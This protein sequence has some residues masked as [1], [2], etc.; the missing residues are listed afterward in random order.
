MN[1]RARLSRPPNAQSLSLSSPRFRRLP[2]RWA[3]AVALAFG[4]FAAATRPAIGGAHLP[5]G[6]VIEI[7]SGVYERRNVPISV[8]L[9]TGLNEKQSFSLTTQG[10]AVK[11]AAQVLPGHPPRLVWILDHLAV[12]QMRRYEIQPEG[13]DRQ[14]R[15]VTCQD[16]GKGLI[17]SVD[18]RQALRYEHEIVEAPIGLSSLYRRSGQMHPLTTPS[19]RVVTDD[20]SPDHAHQHGFFFAWVNTTFNGRKV[21]FWNQ[22]QKTGTVRH[23]KTLETTSGPVFAQF[24]VQT[25]HEDLT[26]PETPVAVLDEEITAR[27]YLVSDRFLIDYESRQTC[28]SDKPLQLHQYIYGGLGVRGNRA[29]A[30]PSARG[31]AA[32]SI[33]EWPERLSDERRQTP[34][35]RQS[36]PA[37]LGRSFGRR[38]RQGRRAGGARESHE[39]P[40]PAAGSIASQHALFLGLADSRGRIRHQARRDLC[41]ALSRCPA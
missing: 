41:F 14:G 7:N 1:S 17:L 6:V 40:V 18:G 16:D 9:P 33:A 10:N 28:A 39:L 29:C 20:F 26:A 23:A 36:H 31:R 5:D 34:Q 3:A 11:I 8:P 37:E 35:G 38:G 4:I 30:T 24:R 22:Q 25:R 27:L 12:G 32:R 21:D 2:P 19:G 13:P 15:V